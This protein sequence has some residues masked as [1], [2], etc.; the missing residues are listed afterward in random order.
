M[1]LQNEYN[2]NNPLENEE[3]LLRDN[4]TIFVRIY[5]TIM[6]VNVN[7]MHTD[8]EWDVMVGRTEALHT[9]IHTTYNY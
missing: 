6:L 5:G 2:S 3:R 9:Y 8:R 1:Q 4:Y 7:V